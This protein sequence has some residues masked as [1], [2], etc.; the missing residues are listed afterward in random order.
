MKRQG[1]FTYP[2]IDRVVFGMPFVEALKTEADRLGVSR[3]FVLA[4]GTL[5]RETDCLSH[6][7][8]EMGGRIVGV[9]DQLQR[10]EEHTS[11]LQSAVCSSDLCSWS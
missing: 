8:T 10:A 2:E 3:I 6:L 5:V 7:E 4:S 1:V 9:Y 11:D